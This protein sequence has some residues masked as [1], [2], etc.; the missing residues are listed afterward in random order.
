MTALLVTTAPAMSSTLRP[1][2][3]S[4]DTRAAGWTTVAKRSGSIPS[5]SMT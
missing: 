4:G 5:L 2:L 3:A 1:S